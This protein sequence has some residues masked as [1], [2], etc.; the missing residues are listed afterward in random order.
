MSK[1]LRTQPLSFEGSVTRNTNQLTL[2]EIRQISKNNGLQVSRDA[3]AL[4][5]SI[6]GRQRKIVF[7][8][9]LQAVRNCKRKRILGRD[10]GTALNIL[11][12]AP[13]F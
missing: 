13:D 7:N 6:K 1:K 4:L 8:S 10:V 11:T 2:K 9:S 5:K 3:I 12:S